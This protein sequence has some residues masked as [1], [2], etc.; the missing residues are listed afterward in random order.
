MSLCMQ[1]KTFSTSASTD[2]KTSF[3]NYD[4]VVEH[5]FISCYCPSDLGI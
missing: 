3:F 5:D 2:S 1:K 4:L